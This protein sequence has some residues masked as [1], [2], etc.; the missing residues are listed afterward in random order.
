MRNSTMR[1]A[2][3]PAGAGLI[4]VA[5]HDGPDLRCSFDTQHFSAVVPSARGW[6]QTRSVV[7]LHRTNRASR[8]AVLDDL[9]DRWAVKARGHFPS[10]AAALTRLSLV[11][12]SLDPTGRAQV[13]C[14]PRGLGRV[15]DSLSNDNRRCLKRCHRYSVA[16]SFHFWLR[17]GFDCDRSIRLIFRSR[18]CASPVSCGSRVA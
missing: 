16:N 4:G 15:V 17:L 3:P 8:R 5:A 6:V 14:L 9:A 7:E 11:T 18:R 10:Q 13:V 1:R 12:R 2:G